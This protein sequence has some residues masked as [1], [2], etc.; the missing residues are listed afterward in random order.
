MGDNL[1]TA[2]W[3][4][5]LPNIISQLNEGKKNVQIEVSDLAKYGERP[6]GYYSNFRIV[7][8]A[9]INPKNAHAPGRDLYSVFKENKYFK[10]NLGNKIIQLTISND[11]KLKIE[12]LATNA[13]DFFT[14]DDFIELSKFARKVK[15]VGNVEHQTTYDFLRGTYLKIDYWVN[16]VQKR[17]YPNGVVRI[18]QKPTNQAGIFEFYQWAKLYPDRT[19]YDYN[20]L[21]FTLG[22]NTDNSHFSIKVDTISLDNNDPRRQKYLH[23][24]GDYNNSPLG[25]NLPADQVIDKGWKYL[26]DLTINIIISLKPSFDLLLKSFLDLTAAPVIQKNLNSSDMALNTILYGPPG[27]GKT[28]NSINKSLEIVG[29]DTKG[30]PRKDIRDAFDK[31]VQE[32][33]IVFSTFHQSMS[34]EDFIEGIKPVKPDNNINLHYDIV[35]GIFKRIC[36]EARRKDQFSIKIEEENIKPLDKELFEEFYYSFSENLPKHTESNS[37]VIL[38]TKDGYPFELFKNTVDSIVVK[39]GTKRTNSTVALSEL[40]AV[41]FENK[42]PTYKSYEQIIIDKILEDKNFK[43]SEIDNTTKNYVLIVDEINR[44]NVSQIFG[45]LI[46]L[47]EED[48]REGK[49]EALNIVLPYSKKIFSVPSNV[50]IL[51]TM[52]TA[53]R[54]VEALD[55]ALRRRF[56]FEELMPKPEMI[57]SLFEDSLLNDCVKYDNIGFDHKDWTEVENNYIDLLPKKAYFDFQTEVNKTPAPRD[58]TFY[59]KKWDDANVVIISCKILATINERIE[60]LINRDHL[61]GHAYFMGKYTWES[62]QITF[63]KNIIPLLQEYFYGDYGKI[64]LVLGKGFVKQKKT[65]NK[66]GV[67]ADFDYDSSSFEDKL[68]YELVD[69]SQVSN[70]EIEYNKQRVQMTFQKAIQILLKHEIE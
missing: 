25:K 28:Y 60:V 8:G 9:L 47:I 34:Y 57:N 62:L 70:Y 38:R 18:L 69:Y 40:N 44:G 53:D 7:N 61:I 24:R 67:F 48:K 11:L 36:L 43:K 6:R 42:I 1:Y 39:A 27:T 49:K 32:G 3:Q 50:F 68:I 35:D 52:N 59:K 13:P 26:I 15:E 10:E 17:L 20:A 19:S 14:E 22:I 51:G 16:Q 65:H 21:A 45:E 23:E 5:V 66:E 58:Y 29:F 55:T 31:K 63:Y 41:L 46:T 12:I 64:G 37:T 56:V 2:Y 4:S 54:S 33:Q 30:K